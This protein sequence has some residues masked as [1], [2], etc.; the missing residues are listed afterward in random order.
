MLY[1]PSL[2]YR[3][4]SFVKLN[5]LISILKRTQLYGFVLISDENRGEAIG[6]SVS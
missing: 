5:T 6:K 4:L 1:G 2:E 3:A